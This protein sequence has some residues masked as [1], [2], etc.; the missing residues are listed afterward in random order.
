[1]AGAR[2]RLHRG[3]RRAPVAAWCL[4]IVGL[5]AGIAA[6]ATAQSFKPGRIEDPVESGSFLLRVFRDS[7][8]LPQNTVHA[9]TLDSRGY[10]WV[11]TQ[12]GAAFYNGRGWT[13]VNLPDRT[14]SNF[15]RCIEPGQHGDLWFG[16]QGGLLRLAEGSWRPVPGLPLALVRQRI[17][18]VVES[19]AGAASVLWIAT[20]GQGLWRLQGEQWRRFDTTSGLP[21]DRV[22]ALFETTDRIEG[23]R[24][25]V[26]T[27]EGLAYIGG[28]GSAVAAEPQSPSASVNSFVETVGPDGSR[29][30][31]AG[32]YGAGVA[33]RSGGVWRYYTMRD[34][35]PSDF[36]TSL[37]DAAPGSAVPAVW[38]GTDGGG[39]ARLD[40]DHVL[41]LIADPALPSNAVYSMV[42]TGAADGTEALWV[43]TRNGGLARLREGQWRSFRPI[44]GAPWMSVN[45]VLESG[46]RSGAP[47]IWFGVDGGGLAR[48]QGGRWTLITAAAGGL[49]SDD[50]QCL[51]ET[52]APDG[53]SAVWVG[54]RNGGLARYAHGGWRVFTR[55]SGALPNDIVQSL[56]ETRDPDGTST[57]WV[58][59]RG[60]L[61]RL[62]EGRWSTIAPEA[63]PNPSVV[64]LASETGGVNG[65]ALWVGTAGGL[66]R[67]E[68][69]SWRRYG[70]ELGLL[71][72][73][74]QALHASRTPEGLRVL[75]IGTDGGGVS[76]LDTAQGKLLFTLTDGSEPALPNNVVYQIL[77]DAKGR[78]YLPTNKGVARLVV[79]PGKD[80]ERGA[81]DVFTFTWEDGLPRNQC[82]RAA[83]MVDASGRIWVGTVGGAAVLDSSR[84]W[85]DRAPK[86]LA[87]D[88]WVATDRQRPLRS[89]M[90]LEHT[91]RHVVFEYGLLSFFRE[92][93][94]RYRTQ[95]VGPDP[96]PSEWGTD[97][98]REYRALPPGVYT[99]RVWGRDYA[100]NVSGPHELAFG[101]LPA[102]WQTW[103]AYLFVAVAGVGLVTL[104]V[105]LR[106]RRH[107]RREDELR[108]LV[109]ARTRELSE[110]NQ[111][112][113]ELSY[114]DPLTGIANRRRFEERL[115]LEWKRALRSRSPLAMIM[116][117]I[118]LFKDFNDT[119]GHQRGDACLKAV[120]AALADGLPRSGDSVARYGGEEF[121][122]V[123]PLTAQAGA[124][125]V[126]EQLRQRVEALGLP[127]R[128]STV[129]RC[130]TISCGVAAM[131]PESDDGLHALVRIADEALYRAKLAG[132][133]RSEA[134]GG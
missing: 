8:G 123:L 76:C 58:G 134:A 69:G 46:D 107:E 85:V 67:L 34:G 64:A 127:H 93:E 117:D 75:W 78:I 91:S 62:R 113:M 101:V 37:A 84:D 122:V 25:W 74:V 65:A 60:G 109:D 130:V 10:L 21:S 51:L 59:T 22:W 80:W 43:G 17:N 106:L 12:D 29:H 52:A 3:G 114:L 35:L 32:T 121:A 88:G 61:A 36:V 82:N 96:K 50:V 89:G 72:D 13:V 6:G 115:L 79:R 111:L 47:A 24:L 90:A 118:D 9:V 15:V 97:V 102:P 27:E 77:E 20:H 95:L 125:R 94:T 119:Y 16:T 42:R 129:A 131:V 98:R 18:A 31:W 44:A 110:A 19:R 7:D 105:S 30:L 112:L 120:A 26:G 54:T 124:V 1:V 71:N 116:V 99:F 41:P 49:P 128:S 38:V 40:G 68:N 66:A 133:N 4:L 11:G 39:L 33:R 126:A 53:S 28:N 103:W 56:L 108:E 81:F 73:T 87:L 63:L 14:H 48:L 132:R 70:P 86:R 57:L 5:L 23:L 55:E 92:G 104:L 2:N 100:G 83:G 45:A